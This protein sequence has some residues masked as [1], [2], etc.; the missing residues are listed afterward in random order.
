MAPL[1]V[2]H[3]FK[4]AQ[5]N[6][7]KLHT[8]CFQLHCEFSKVI[9]NKC[10]DDDYCMKTVCP[11][12]RPYRGLRLGEIPMFSFRYTFDSY[13]TWFNLVRFLSSMSLSSTFDSFR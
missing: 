8:T 12:I 9:D 10:R 5:Q 1:L 6:S 11:K 2:G 3:S 4:T 13:P 7:E